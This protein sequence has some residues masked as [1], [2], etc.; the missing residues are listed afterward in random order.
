METSGGLQNMGDNNITVLSCQGRLDTN[1]SLCLLILKVN[2]SG[3]LCNTNF[4]NGLVGL[5][6]LCLI[7]I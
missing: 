6:W 4:Q 7:L 3:L 1:L 5:N 2:R